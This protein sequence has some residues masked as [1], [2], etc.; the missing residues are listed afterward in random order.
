MSSVN[1]DRLQL[2]LVYSVAA[3]MSFRPREAKEVFVSGTFDDWGKTIQLQR[4]GDIFEKEVQLPSTS[5][6]I[7][8]KVRGELAVQLFSFGFSSVLF[9]S[10]LF[11]S[12]LFCSPTTRLQSGHPTHARDTRQA[13]YY[14]YRP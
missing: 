8:Y 5:E 12:V 13:L 3:L 9:V 4:K 10:V 11:F 2:S 14:V 6:K 7:Q 1:F